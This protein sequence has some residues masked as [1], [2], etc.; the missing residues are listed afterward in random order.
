[1][2]Q[3]SRWRETAARDPDYSKCYKNLP[4]PSS[5]CAYVPIISRHLAR[6]TNS[7]IC[8]SV[9]WP[10]IVGINIPYWSANGCETNIVA[11]NE[12]KTKIIKN[13]ATNV[14]KTEMKVINNIIFSGVWSMAYFIKLYLI[15]NILHSMEEPQ[16]KKITVVAC[17]THPKLNKKK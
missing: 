9:P 1:M 11:L 15:I 8:S 16:N 4:W 6:G 5:V 13:L 14:C 17:Q 10:L 2:V 7:C 3:T 12:N